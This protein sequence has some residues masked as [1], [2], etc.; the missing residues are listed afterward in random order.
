MKTQYKTI[1]GQLIIDFNEKKSKFIGL[2][3]HCD[4]LEA[5]FA[6]LS[7]WKE[8][9]PKASHLCYAYRIGIENAESR[10]YDDGEPSNS[11]GAPILGQIKSFDLTNTLIGVIR[12]YG[13]TN[14]GVGGLIQAYKKAAKFVIQANL[15]VEKEVSQLMRIFFSAEQMPFLM[16]DLKQMDVSFSNAKLDVFCE[17][18][19]ALPLSKKSEFFDRVQNY[20]SLTYEILV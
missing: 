13:G 5:V 20:D 10:A 19:I 7:Q 14:L 1:E 16:N 4:S 2:I 8:E 17:M 6:R 3:A 12:Y 15:I 9:H 11:A 18:D